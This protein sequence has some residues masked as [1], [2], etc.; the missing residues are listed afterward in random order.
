MTVLITLIARSFKSQ[1]RKI[2]VL[3]SVY[4][5]KIKSRHLQTKYGSQKLH[6][7]SVLYQQN[8]LY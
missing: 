7:E 8:Y 3:K 4:E 1:S 5:K 2:K 6:M